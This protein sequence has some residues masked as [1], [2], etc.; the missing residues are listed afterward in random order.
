LSFS[1]V[2]RSEAVKKAEQV[3]TQYKFRS[4]LNDQKQSIYTE[5]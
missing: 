3:I 1:K 2:Y 4:N 5:A